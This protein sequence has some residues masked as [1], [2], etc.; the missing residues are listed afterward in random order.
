MLVL[1]DVL[2][3][4]FILASTFALV[5]LGLRALENPKKKPEDKTEEN[6]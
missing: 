3:A 2:L 6:K 5:A 1:T 4:V